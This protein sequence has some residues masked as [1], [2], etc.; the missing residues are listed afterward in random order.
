MADEDLRVKLE[1]EGKSGLRELAG[2]KTV[3]RFSFN[4]ASLYAHEFGE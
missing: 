2:Q 4:F 3:L 1:W